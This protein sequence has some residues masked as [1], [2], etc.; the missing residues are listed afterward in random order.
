MTLRS[1]W[2]PALAA[3]EAAARHQNFAHAGEELHLTASAVSHHVR[4][5]E[6]RLGVMLFQR[7]AR[8]VS[9][10][11]EGR[12]L[13]DASGNALAE[14]EDVLSG[15]RTS[16]GDGERVR[17]TA[18]HSFTTAWIVPRLPDFAARHPD[19]RISFETE[20]ALTRFDDQ[21][22]DLGVRHGP[23]HWPGLSAQRLLEEPLFPVASPAL[24]G[25]DRIADP[26]DIAR[27]PLV[28]DLSRHG[29]SDWFRAAGVR[30]ARPMER[31][32]FS[33]STD[34]LE[35]AA[36]GLGAALARRLV[37]VPWL[38]S[39]RLLRLPGPELPSR[40]AY[41]IVHPSHRPLRPAARLFAE[42]LMDMAADALPGR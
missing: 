12:R 32:T 41:F 28:G 37:V 24:A 8:G 5:L 7:H 14:L 33:D 15:L 17:V 2:L 27:L 18:L 19:I 23:G 25:V 22:P 13:A 29:W 16:Q 4:K 38:A 40:Y 3:F 26:A 9:L 20:I 10:T 35:A 1:D 36:H 21:G 42:W 31:F 34:M 11:A 39:G 6:A 30:G